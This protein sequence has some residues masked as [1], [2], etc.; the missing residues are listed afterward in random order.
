MSKL[1]VPLVAASTMLALFSQTVNLNGMKTAGGAALYYQSQLIRRPKLGDGCYH[2]FLDVGANIGIHTRFLYE[3]DL[4]P[5]SKTSVAAFAEKFGYP[6]ENDNFCVF[7]FEPNPKFEQRHLNLAKA[8]NA[9]GWRYTPLLAGVS[10]AN[11]NMTFY[12][13]HLEKMESEV[14][15]SAVAAKTLYGNDATPKTVKIIR[16]ATWIHDEIQERVIPKSHGQ[17]MDP[18]VILKLDVEGLEYKVF[19]DLLTTGALCQNIDHLIGEFHYGPGN[20][21]FFPMN[22]TSDGTHKLNQRKDGKALAMQLLRMVD[23]SENCRTTISLDDDES[24]LTDPHPYPSP[25]VNTTITS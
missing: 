15:F 23:I 11:G 25:N 17:I 19:P 21:N 1:V 8:Y 6:R 12:H 2:I 18:K 5:N 13:T 7:G 4:Y 24:Y 20:H 3:P 10:N 14:G 9:M 16:L 22:L